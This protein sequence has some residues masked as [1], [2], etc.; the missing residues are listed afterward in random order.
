MVVIVND[1]DLGIR[2]DNLEFHEG[3]GTPCKH[4]TGPGPGEYSCA[5][6]DRPWYEETPCFRH[7]QH[8]ASLDTPCRLGEFTLKETTQTEKEKENA[9]QRTSAPDG[10]SGTHQDRGA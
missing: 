5:V 4:L 9:D 1:P 3:Q 10:R 6:H 2:E 8:E 7:V